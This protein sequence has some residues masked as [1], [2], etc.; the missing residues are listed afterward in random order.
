[1]FP[2][3]LALAAWIPAMLEFQ[4]MSLALGEGE[5][6]DRGA[7]RATSPPLMSARNP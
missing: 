2:P 5:N 6:D 1:M 7:P 4:N 3:L